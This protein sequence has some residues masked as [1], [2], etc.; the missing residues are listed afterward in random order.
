MTEIIRRFRSKIFLDT[1]LFPVPHLGPCWLW[2]GGK[3]SDGYAVFKVDGVSVNAH[4][5]YYQIVNG[6]LKSFIHL[7]HLCRIRHCVN[8]EHLE[9]VSNQENLLRGL[10]FQAFNS[11]KTHCPRGHEY[12]STNTYI[13]KGNTRACRVC[14]RLH[15]ISYKERKGA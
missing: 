15:Q 10:T 5:W 13:T 8:P 7:D 11:Q 14:Q 4:R 9:P 6:E 12:N 1:L 2:T 3:D